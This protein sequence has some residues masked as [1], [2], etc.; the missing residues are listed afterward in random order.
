MNRDAFFAIEHPAGNAVLAAPGDRRRDESPR[1][2]PLREFELRGGAHA[3]SARSGESAFRP[4]LIA[5]TRPRTMLHA[6]I[7]CL[8]SPHSVGSSRHTS[9][10][11]VA[12]HIGDLD[13]LCARPG[14]FRTLAYRFLSFVIIALSAHASAQQMPGTGAV[15]RHEVAAAGPVSR[16]PSDRGRG[17]SRRSDNLLLRHARRRSLEDDRRRTRLASDLRQRTGAV[18]RCRDGRTSASNVIY[19][20]TGEQTRGKGIYRST[21]SGKT[22]SNAG[23]QDVPLHPGNHCRSAES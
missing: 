6:A 19:A 21:D 1:P 20:G 16:R 3:G 12:L 9:V 4:P 7:A 14:V 13:A 18:H 11:R 17:R 5:P 15:L 22:W 10:F 23:L 2:A 8:P